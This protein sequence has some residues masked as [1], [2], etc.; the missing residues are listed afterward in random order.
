MVA[1][2]STKTDKTTIYRFA[3]I[4][5]R[6][7]GAICERVAGDV[8]DPEWLSGLVDI[9][10]DEISWTKHYNYLTLVSDHP[11]GDDCVG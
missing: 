1:W 2:L 7:V 11:G 9:G 8:L 5:W 6:T 3:R 4:G 10:V